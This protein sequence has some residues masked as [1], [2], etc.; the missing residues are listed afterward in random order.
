MSTKTIKKPTSLDDTTLIDFYRQMAL[1][2]VF[3]ERCAEQYMLGKIRG[4]VHLYIGQEAVAVGAISVLQKDDYVT[5]HYRDHGHAL[6]RGLTPNSVM[7]E[8]FGKSTGCS[9]GMGGSMH[10]FDA[11]SN[12]AGGYAIVAGHLPLANGLAFAFKYNNDKRLVATFFGDGALNE[13]E[14]HEVMNMAAL[15]KLPVIFVCENNQYGMGIP[16][17][18]SMAN[19]KLTEMAKAY[20]MP[21]AKVDGMNVLAVRDATEAAVKHVRAGNGP[22]FLEF[23]TY[24]FRGHSMA[25]PVLYRTKEEEGKYR[26]L[27]PILTFGEWLISNKKATQDQLD[28]I[29][30]AIEYIVEESVKFADESPFPKIDDLYKN[31][32]AETT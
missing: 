7:A 24:R 13:G 11:P 12:F 10:L 28:K 32:Y 27:D 22:Y 4:F 3:E 31:I 23:S 2:R 30:L 15:W 16:L 5:T 6:A 14:A 9:K 8:L 25:D 19:P 1:L 21:S 17:E 26:K 20:G 18:D 29:N